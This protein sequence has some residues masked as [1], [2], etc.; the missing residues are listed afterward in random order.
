MPVLKIILSVFWINLQPFIKEII[1]YKNKDFIRTTKFKQNNK[2]SIFGS[3]F[4]T[5]SDY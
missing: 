4:C 3:P 5:Y 2:N 1:I